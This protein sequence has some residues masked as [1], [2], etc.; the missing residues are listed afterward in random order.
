[1]GTDTVA[2]FNCTKLEVCRVYDAFVKFSETF[3][4]SFI[5]VNTG[6]EYPN[7]VKKI[8]KTLALNCQSYISED[9]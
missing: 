8:E 7:A 5:G 9:E 1:M 6:A 4:C 3:K 2:C